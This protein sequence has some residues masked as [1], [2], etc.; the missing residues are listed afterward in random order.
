MGYILELGHF[1]NLTTLHLVT[2]KHLVDIRRVIILCCPL[3][4]SSVLQST[5]VLSS[6]K[7]SYTVYKRIVNH[8]IGQVIQ[9]FFLFLGVFRSVIYKSELFAPDIMLRTTL[10]VML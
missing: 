3:R 2:R 9:H 10:Y 4:V 1:D 8:Y 7:I 6:K 5:L